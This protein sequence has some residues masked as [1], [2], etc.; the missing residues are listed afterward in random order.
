M[1]KRIVQVE[2]IFCGANQLFLISGPS[3]IE[4]ERVM[5]KTAQRP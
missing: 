2:D 3:V 1:K 5:L 4:K